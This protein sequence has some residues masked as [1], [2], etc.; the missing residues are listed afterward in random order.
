MDEESDVG[1]FGAV[2][3]GQ[4]NLIMSIKFRVSLNTGL[5]SLLEC[6]T[7]TCIELECRTG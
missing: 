6:G 3:K 1:L 7:G 2:I 4:L 5:D